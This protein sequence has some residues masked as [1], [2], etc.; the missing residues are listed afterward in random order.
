LAFVFVHG[1]HHVVANAHHVVFPLFMFGITLS[2][3]C[4]VGGVLLE[5]KVC[6]LLATL[7]KAFT[8]QVCLLFS[9][10]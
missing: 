10:N 9:Q 5:A 1:I 3:H 8:F 2:L 7:A 6:Y 4:H